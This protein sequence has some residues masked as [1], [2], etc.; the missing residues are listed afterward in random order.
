VF[1]GGSVWVIIQLQYCVSGGS[2]CVIVQFHYCV[3]WWLFLHYNSASVLLFPSH[4]LNGLDAFSLKK[5][6]LSVENQLTGLSFY[7]LFL[8]SSNRVHV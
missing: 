6:R 7:A 1:S 5:F 8:Y 3:F 2:F 4:D